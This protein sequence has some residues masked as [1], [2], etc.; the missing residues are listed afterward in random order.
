MPRTLNGEKWE[1]SFREEVRNVLPGLT[2]SDH[3]EFVRL[4][5]R[6]VAGIEALMKSQTALLKK[7]R[8]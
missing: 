2:V 4:R 7:E 8:S 3:N 5:Y 1:Q 6:T